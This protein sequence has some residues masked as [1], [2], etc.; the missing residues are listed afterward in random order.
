MSK[1]KKKRGFRLIVLSLLFLPALEVLFIIG[2]NSDYLVKRPFL[3]LI[4]GF[5]FLFT[6]FLLLC[7]LISY[8]IF[9]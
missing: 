7:F 5:I 9:I 2:C 8:Y 4:I 1:K 6:F 3:Y